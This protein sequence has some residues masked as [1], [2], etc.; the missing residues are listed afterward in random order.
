MEEIWKDIKGY[1]G[2]YQVSNLGR[3]KSLLRKVPHLGGYR[4][5]PERVVKIHKSS[6]TGYKM[7][8]LCK[9]STYKL[10]LVHRLVAEAFVP[11]PHNLPYVNHKNEIRTDNNAENL[12]WCTPNY[13]IEYSH[14]R[15]RL[16]FKIQKAVEQYDLDGRL[17]KVYNS[18]KI[19]GNVIGVSPS[20][21]A[22][23]CNGK[24]GSVKGYLWKFKGVEKKSKT[25]ARCRRVIQK[26]MN[27]NTINIWKSIKE[28]A[29][30]THSS[31][32]GILACCQGKRN[33]TKNFFKWEYYDKLPITT[34]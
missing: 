32:H 27:G 24:I 30:N 22:K 20:S 6:T 26:D 9:N 17:V 23:C 5:I 3:V 10:Y 12:E 14:V 31:V 11:N 15:E 8:H 2:L 19:A 1:E 7:A 18:T 13:N 29:E 25:R 4:T 33:K 34:I 21:I 16:A 28:A